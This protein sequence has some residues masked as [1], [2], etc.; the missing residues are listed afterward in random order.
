MPNAVWPLSLPQEPDIGHI[1]EAP[2]N[3][4]RTQMDVGPP[5]VRRRYTAAV[6]SVEMPLELDDAQTTTLHDF[7]TTTLKDGADLFDWKLPR[8]GGAVTFRFVKPPKY[9]CIHPK[10]YQTVLSLEILP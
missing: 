8:T 5:K 6:R 1:E 4:L 7:F 2:N 10:R 9:E 3:L